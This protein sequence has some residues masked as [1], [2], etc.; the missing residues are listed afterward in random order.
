MNER[1]YTEPTHSNYV[2]F[3]EEHIAAY[4]KA[5]AQGNARQT[6]EQLAEAKAWLQAALHDLDKKGKKARRTK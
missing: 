3:A 6:A 5:L 1:T 4:K 2:R